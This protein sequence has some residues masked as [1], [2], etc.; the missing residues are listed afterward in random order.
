MNGVH[1]LGGMDGF[2]PIVPEA[3]EPVFHHDWERRIFGVALSSPFFQNL[4]AGRHAIERMPPAEY[5]A[6]SYY[7]H[8][9]SGLERGLIESGTITRQEIEEALRNPREPQRPQA[10]PNRVAPPEVP[11]VERPRKARF[12]V[13]DSVIARNLNPPGHTRLP[14]YVRGHR[15]TVHH[16]WGVFTY[17]DTNAH[18]LGRKPQHCYG[19][20]F[21]ARELWGADHP[22][23][24]RI[25]IDLWEDYL[26]IDRNAAAKRPTKIKRTEGRIKTVSPRARKAASV[27]TRPT[28][29][30]RAKPTRKR[31]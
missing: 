4:D 21:S 24:E 1:D 20:E 27:R 3:N 13:G 16:D 29:K 17:P 30:K 2:G 10:A 5:L 25:F 14:R 22:A 8:W 11:A 15:G 26:D 7:A 12:R 28:P 19:V 6:S 31:R 18:G 9:L 23:A